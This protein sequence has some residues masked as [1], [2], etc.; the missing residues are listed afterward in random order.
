MHLPASRTTVRTGRLAAGPVC[1]DTRT[2]H[3]PDALVKM[4]RSEAPEECL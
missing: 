4:V 3:S 1:P 2:L